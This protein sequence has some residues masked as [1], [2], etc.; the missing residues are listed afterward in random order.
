[1]SKSKEPQLDRKL[2]NQQ[3]LEYQKTKSEELLNTIIQNRLP[4]LEY[5]ANLK[6]HD[7]I[8]IYVG[9]KSDLASALKVPLINAINQFKPDL[10]DFNT[11]VY[12]YIEN[13]IRNINSACFAK[14]RKN[15][16]I[17]SLDQTVIES[18]HSTI[19]YEDMVV[20]KDIDYSFDDSGLDKI[21]DKI[22]T[23]GNI[24]KFRKKEDIKSLLTKI[25]IGGDRETKE[26]VSVKNAIWRWVEMAQPKQVAEFREFVIKHTE[27]Q[28]YIHTNNAIQQF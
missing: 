20:S 18:Q 3:V 4:T 15:E 14:R 17:F 5:F 22:Y 6:Y 21:V 7:G 12:T 9:D 13:Y 25:I 1:M 10:R 27:R 19:T 11:L 24:D 2:E 23:F 26:E 16:G 28:Q 8:R